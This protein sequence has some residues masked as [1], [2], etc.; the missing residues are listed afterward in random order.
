MGAASGKYI[1]SRHERQ[2]PVVVLMKSNYV[3]HFGFR[4][5]TLIG[6][7]LEIFRVQ[8]CS[9]FSAIN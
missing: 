2:I 3:W 7:V 4:V 5:W 8:N 6:I 1:Y 9:W